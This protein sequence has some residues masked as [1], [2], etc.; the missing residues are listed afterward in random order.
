MPSTT[1]YEESKWA[2]KQEKGQKHSCR[3]AK[4]EEAGQP[5]A[6]NMRELVW[7]EELEAIAQRFHLSLIIKFLQSYF[8]AT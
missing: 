1:S 4:G 2:K 5:G 8:S 3:V 6:S 7:D